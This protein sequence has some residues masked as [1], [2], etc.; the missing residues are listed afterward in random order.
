[1]PYCKSAI[2]IEATAMASDVLF[3]FPKAHTF[4][5]KLVDIEEVRK[6]KHEESHDT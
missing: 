5:C 3:A 2:K 1:M 6:L 4:E